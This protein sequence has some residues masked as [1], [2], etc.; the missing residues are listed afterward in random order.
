M[1]VNYTQHAKAECLQPIKPAEPIEQSETEELRMTSPFRMIDW[2]F[3]GE[4]VPPHGIII[5]FLQDVKV[6]EPAAEWTRGRGLC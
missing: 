5:A 2:R 1:P 6:N 3:T 4:R